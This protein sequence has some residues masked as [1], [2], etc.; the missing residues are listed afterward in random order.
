[1]LMED[2]SPVQEV[3]SEVVEHQTTTSQKRKRSS[4]GEVSPP[5]KSKCLDALP[6]KRR[7][8]LK[9]LFAEG[10]A[11][12]GVNPEKIDVDTFLEI[13]MGYLSQN[14]QVILLFPI[15]MGGKCG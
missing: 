13:V 8:K 2:L 6:S 10:L 5:L 14:E 4:S 15:P 1:M 9:Q 11:K 3:V 12:E 7:T